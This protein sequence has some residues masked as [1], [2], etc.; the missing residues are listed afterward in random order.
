EPDRSQ[1]VAPAVVAEHRAAGLDQ[2]S[3][4]RHIPGRRSGRDRREVEQERLARWAAQRQPGDADRPVAP[5]TTE[6]GEQLA[7][8]LLLL[9]SRRWLRPDRRQ[10]LAG[11][12][13]TLTAYPA[14]PPVERQRRD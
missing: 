5:A 1:G 13:R 11:E 10:Q 9:P 7:E 3:Q 2:P 14:Q 6:R 4:L 8:Q 12:Q